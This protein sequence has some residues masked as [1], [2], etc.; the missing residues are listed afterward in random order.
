[1]H[2]SV[3][4]SCG[5]GTVRS[6]LVSK[7]RKEVQQLLILSGRLVWQLGQDQLVDCQSRNDMRRRIR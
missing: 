7:L 2:L 4:K 1:V 5:E 6:K 3:R